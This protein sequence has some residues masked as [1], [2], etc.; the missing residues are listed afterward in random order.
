MINTQ[1]EERFYKTNV[2]IVNPSCMLFNP[3]TKAVKLYDFE[4]SQHSKQS[5][6]EFPQP[7]PQPNPPYSPLDSRR[8]DTRYDIYSL[9]ISVPC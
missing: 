5:L 6:L 7:K 9:G 4:S 3:S 8:L 1:A 2:T